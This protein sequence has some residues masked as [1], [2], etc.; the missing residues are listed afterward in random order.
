MAPLAV[1]TLL[2]VALVV[3]AWLGAVVYLFFVAQAPN[4]NDDK[5]HEDVRWDWFPPP[6]GGGGAT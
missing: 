1:V 3:L 2:I 5:D 4:S 6:G